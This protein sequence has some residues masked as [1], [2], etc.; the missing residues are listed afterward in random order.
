M[1]E[2]TQLMLNGAEVKKLSNDIPKNVSVDLEI[3]K[4]TPRAPDTVI[5]D[6]VYTISY[7]PNVAKLSVSGIA[8]CRDSPEN[9]KK[10]IDHHKKKKPLPFDLAGSAI[11]MIN[12]NVG[13]NSIFILR[14]FGLIPHFMPP[15]I[16]LPEGAEPPPKETKK[17]R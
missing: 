13:M 3:E 15:P 4:I 7:G 8:L 1:L 9:I 2:M 16:S 17:S 11:N 5:L 14:P 10:V 12:S 6:F